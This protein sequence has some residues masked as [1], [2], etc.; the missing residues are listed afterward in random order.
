MIT[1]KYK[2]VEIAYSEKGNQWEFTYDGEERVAPSL[3]LAKKRIDAKPKF[4]RIPCWCIGRYH[5]DDFRQGEVTCL[6]SGGREA[7]VTVDGSR[8]KTYARNVYLKNVFNDL[9]IGRIR[10]LRKQVEELEE[11]INAESKKL[12]GLPEVKKEEA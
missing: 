12:Q 8:E 2:G 11:Q 7:W 3:A 10:A 9:L 6:T 4:K 1:E 5:D